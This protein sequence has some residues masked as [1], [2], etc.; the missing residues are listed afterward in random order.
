MKKLLIT[1][2]LMLSAPFAAMAVEA[3]AASAP[4]AA[5]PVA[6]ASAG[7][8]AQPKMCKKAERMT[9]ELGLNAE[10][11][12]KVNAIFEQQKEKRKALREEMHKQL[13]AVLT[14]E[15][16]AKMQAKHDSKKG[17]HGKG[18]IHGASDDE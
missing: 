11:Q 2:T 13:E 14:P 4:V 18:D 7:A 3:T 9:K 12:A 15:Q 5:A 17:K 8:T 6:P 10:Q 16:M 1:L